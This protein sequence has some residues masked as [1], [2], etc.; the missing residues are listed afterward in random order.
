MNRCSG[1]HSF[2]RS[3]NF[4]LLDSE[5]KSIQYSSKGFASTFIEDKHLTLKQQS[6]K[7][8][9]LAEQFKFTQRIKNK[10]SENTESFHSTKSRS[11]EINIPAHSLGKTK[12]HEFSSNNVTFKT[13]SP[14]ELLKE[15]KTNSL[16][17]KPKSA[18]AS[19]SKNKFQTENKKEKISQ[20]LKRCVCFAPNESKEQK[21]NVSILII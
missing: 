20:K 17:I 10:S 14:E 18:P 3:T 19:L 1:S 12:S 2:S 6:N 7:I 21:V 15:T 11:S 9:S 5:K 4:T 13:S 16:R 8:S